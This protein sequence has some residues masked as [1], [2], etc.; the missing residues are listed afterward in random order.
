ME[1]RNTST[2]CQTARVRH[3]LVTAALGTA[4]AA[5]GL[6]TVVRLVGD[7]G[8]ILLVLLAVVTPLV[9]LPLALLLAVHLVLRRWVLAGVTGVLVVLN[10]CWLIPLYVGDDVPAG[11]P[12]TVL[13]A[14]LYFGRADPDALVRMVKA[15]HVDVLALEELTDA[16]VGRLRLAGLDALLPYTDL[17]AF[18]DADGSGI[19]SRYP[20]EKL[21]PFQARFQSPGATIHVPGGDVV[22]RVIHA[23]PATP[24]G[25]SAYRADYEALTRQVRALPPDNA[26]LAGD[27]NASQD[28]QSFRRLAGA[29]FRDASEVAGSGVQ[30]TWGVRPGAIALLHLDHVLVEYGVAARSTAVLP[31]PGSDHRALLARLVVRVR[32]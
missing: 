12:L 6:P 5:L 18:R 29:R 24:A 14:N 16:A 4:T 11:Q 17:L 21:P 22:F 28:S 1:V 27:F 3:R 30:R 7:H 15:Q 23:I 2:G 9:A 31:L 32:H 13:T 26:V 10:A 19:Y 25:D 8:R 20:L